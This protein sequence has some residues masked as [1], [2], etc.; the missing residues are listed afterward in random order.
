MG[1]IVLVLV[2][3]DRRTLVHHIDKVFQVFSVHLSESAYDR[4]VEVE[5]RAQFAVTLVA[6]GNNDL[7]AG[8]QIACDVVLQQFSVVGNKCPQLAGALSALS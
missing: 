5:D 6:A 3:A 4:A 8:V 1:L 2:P 7:R